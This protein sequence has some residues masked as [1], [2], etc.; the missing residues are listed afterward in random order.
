MDQA[1]P[2]WPICLS[3]MMCQRKR[4]WSNQPWWDQQDKNKKTIQ[5]DS[6]QTQ[7]VLCA[8]LCSGPFKLRK[9][10]YEVADKK[11]TSGAISHLPFQPLLPSSLQYG[12]D[13]SHTTLTN[14][15]ITNT[16]RKSLELAK[17]PTAKLWVNRHQS[18]LSP[19]HG[20]G[21]HKRESIR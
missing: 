7:P 19:R 5:T 1:H 9:T 2:H 3:K 8:L 12:L 20:L 10:H 15:A 17:K 13:W 16:N 14:T 11:E 6:W 4:A 18:P 21:R